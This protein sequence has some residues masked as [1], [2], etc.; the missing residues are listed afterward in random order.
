MDI[1]T[2]K[3][4]TQLKEGKAEK[5]EGYWVVDKVKI[6]LYDLIGPKET[7]SVAAY[8]QKA[9]AVIKK[10]HQEKRLPILVGGTG[11]YI[12]SVTD[13]L[14]IPKS[15]PNFELRRKLENTLP[16]LLYKKLK[17]VD[18]VTAS[19]IDENNP[20]RLVRALEVYY[21]TGEPISTLQEKYSPEFDLL[22][23]GLTAPREKLYEN[24][25][26]GVEEW[27]KIGLVEE[28]QELL[29]KGYSLALPSMTSIGYRQISMHL[30]KKLTLEEA[31]QRI[32]FDRHNYIRRQQTWFKR[33]GRV[34]WF[35]IT[36]GD[37]AAKISKLVSQWYNTGNDSS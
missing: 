24:A 17:E 14:K 2:G 28:T 32:K 31:V 35:D 1:A 34:F 11:L 26:R 12:M 37:S 3:E 9:V 19:R 18:P 23:I 5:H 20:R 13:G 8:Q 15:P 7:F 22:F 30:E 36:D 29:K 27:V 6:N 16:A 4:V 21:Q 10:L 25:D 33:D